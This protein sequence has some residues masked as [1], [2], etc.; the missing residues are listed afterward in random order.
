MKENHCNYCGV[1]LPQGL[2]LFCRTHFFQI[3]AKERVKLSSMYSR[4]QDV[5]S[6]VMQCV[7]LIREASDARKASV[8]TQS[9]PECCTDAEWGEI[10]SSA[11]HEQEC[12]CGARMGEGHCCENGGVKCEP[13]PPVYFAHPNQVERAKQAFGESVSIIP[14]EP[15]PVNKT[16]Q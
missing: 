3:P 8:A 12:R 9:K 6:K 5:G 14:T 11:A 4:K 13:K 16:K 1:K 10:T 15:C 7:K 2:A